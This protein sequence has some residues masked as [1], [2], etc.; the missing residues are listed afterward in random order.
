MGCGPGTA[1]LVETTVGGMDV[2]AGATVT[3]GEQALKATANNKANTV[4]FS[5]LPELMTNQHADW[6]PWLNRPGG[7]THWTNN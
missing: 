5:A 1:V 3:A 2:A 6:P 4:V 7:P